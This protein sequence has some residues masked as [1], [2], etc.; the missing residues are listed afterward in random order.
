MP[1][2]FEAGS[3]VAVLE[4]QNVV[5]RVEPRKSLGFLELMPS[6]WQEGKTIL[7]VLGT[8]PDGLF[9]AKSAL[10]NPEIL[11]GLAGDFATI[12]GEQ[13]TVVNTRTS[14]GLG[15]FA[16]A[17]GADIVQEEIQTPEQLPLES[18]VDAERE[19]TQTRESI[20]VVLQWIFGAMFFVVIIALL[21]RKRNRATE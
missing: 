5:Y 10:L 21:T 15:S 20:L 6:P 2:P 18:L 9:A 16:A 7:M 17:V 19:S 8:D 14:L 12:D 11:S 13:Y 1:A 3:N 4:D